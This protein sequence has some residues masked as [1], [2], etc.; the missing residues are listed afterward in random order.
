MIHKLLITILLTFVTSSSV[1]AQG[2]WLDVQVQTDQYAGESSWQI[3]NDSD[4]VAVS[5]P[6]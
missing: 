2:S 6:L 5:P 4:I 1:L 3:L